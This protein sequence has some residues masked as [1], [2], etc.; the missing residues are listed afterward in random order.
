MYSHCDY[1]DL[2]R[3]SIN[4][5]VHLIL[6]IIISGHYIYKYQYT[7]FKMHVRYF[8]LLPYAIDRNSAYYNISYMLY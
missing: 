8:L 7:L 2:L 1:I 6:I 5:I 4:N 3:S